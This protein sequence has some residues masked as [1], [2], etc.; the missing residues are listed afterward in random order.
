MELDST[1]VAAS[2]KSRMFANVRG[3]DKLRSN[4]HLIKERTCDEQT[5][6]YFSRLLFSGDLRRI[7]RIVVT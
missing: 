3:D 1:G 6:S 7:F 5:N 2:E 4:P